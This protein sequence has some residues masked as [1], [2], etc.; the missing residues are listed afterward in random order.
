MAH[1]QPD[2]TLSDGLAAIIRTIEPTRSTGL[3]MTRRN[4]AVFL[5]GLNALLDE[6]RHLETIADRAKWNEKAKRDA[7][8]ARRAGLEAA[9][10]DGTVE[11]LPVVARPTAVHQ[12]EEGGAA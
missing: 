10:A 4:V 3:V 2:V 11:I 12:G 9:I 8:I 7:L 1:L 6:A 5:D